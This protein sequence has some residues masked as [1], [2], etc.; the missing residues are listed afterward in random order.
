M[1]I[2]NWLAEGVLEGL[3]S[4][5]ITGGITGRSWV[6]PKRALLVWRLFPALKSVF[7]AMLDFTDCSSCEI[8]FSLFFDGL[9]ELDRVFELRDIDKRVESLAERASVLPSV[10]DC[11]YGSVGR[12]P[13]MLLVSC[14]ETIAGDVT[15]DT[16]ELRLVS[17]LRTTL[18]LVETFLL[19]PSA[20][21]AVEARVFASL[22]LGTTLCRAKEETNLRFV[23]V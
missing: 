3:L 7:E 13:F 21:S 22:P 10:M 23:G 19:F 18:V 14:I 6:E 2:D 8:V 12:G 15:V 16:R 9:I 11:L 5:I 17:L 20:L 4:V 1:S